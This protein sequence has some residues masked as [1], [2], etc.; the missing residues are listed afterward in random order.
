MIGRILTISETVKRMAFQVNRKADTK[1]MSL[2]S[3][4]NRDPPSHP[5]QFKIKSSL[6]SFENKK[7]NYPRSNLRLLIIR[8]AENKT[9]TPLHLFYFIFFVVFEEPKPSL[10]VKH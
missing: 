1:S 9:R 8:F 3:R 6:I 2:L 10:T 5:D 7:E 4:F